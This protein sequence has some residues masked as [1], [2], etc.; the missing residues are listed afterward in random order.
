MTGRGDEEQNVSSPL[1]LDFSR[2]LSSALAHGPAISTIRTERKIFCVWILQNDFAKDKQNKIE[3]CIDTRTEERKRN[4]EKRHL[5]N[6][7][8]HES[9]SYSLVST[10]ETRSKWVPGLRRT[11]PCELE[12]SFPGVSARGDLGFLWYR[13]FQLRFSQLW[14]ACCGQVLIEHSSTHSL[15]CLPIVYGCF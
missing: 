3:P 10:E 15:F 4:G 2:Q 11:N 5:C 8:W 12:Q 6:I 7:G 14:P 1:S 13:I 9:G